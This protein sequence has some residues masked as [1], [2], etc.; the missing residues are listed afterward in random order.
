[1][2]KGCQPDFTKRCQPDS[3]KIEEII[4][5]FQLQRRPENRNLDNITFNQGVAGSNPARLTLLSGGA[6]DS[7]KT[8]AD[9]RSGYHVNRRNGTSP[10]KPHP[11]HWHR[12]REYP[13][14]SQALA[15]YRTC[16]RVEGLSPRTIEGTESAV[17][18]FAEFLGG[19]V[20]VS[21]ATANDLRRFI[22]A[23]RDRRAFAGHP[24]T[25]TQEHTLAPHTIASYVRAIRSF[26]SFL[27]GE[28]IL[29]LNPMRK[30]KVPRAPCPVPRA[31]RKVY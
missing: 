21:S 31:P 29:P 13:D 20:E 14:F 4:G 23:L 9:P 12:Q 19:D 25:T 18:Y 24:V 28:E 26:F 22:A 11:D 30:V 27:E 7:P 3:L 15:A 5:R 6:P 17:R 1:M 8:N 2:H 16:A 10:G